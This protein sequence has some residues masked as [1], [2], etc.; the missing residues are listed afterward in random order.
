M[1]MDFCPCCRSD[2]QELSDKIFDTNVCEKCSEAHQS[3]VDEHQSG[4]VDS[5]EFMVYQEYLT[6]RLRRGVL[7]AMFIRNKTVQE[8]VDQLQLL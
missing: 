3:V 1:K 6:Q 2:K 7:V 8:A 4:R 5:Y